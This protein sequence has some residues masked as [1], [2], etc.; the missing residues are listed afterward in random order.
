MK[1]GVNTWV[2]SSPLTTSELESLAPKVAGMG[3]DWIEAPLES[4]DD[5]DHERG[6]AIIREHGLGVSACAAMGPDR[7]L[8][9]PDESIRDNGMDY[10]HGAIRAT[11]TLG[12]IEAWAQGTPIRE[13][14]P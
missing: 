12:A 8:I 7:D 13:I 11:Q 10:V 1:F 14:K 6:A 3:F 2:W 5:L 4:L 9:H